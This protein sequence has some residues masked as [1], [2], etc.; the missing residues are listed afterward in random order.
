M[1][2]IHWDSFKVYA[3]D[4]FKPW[5]LILTRQFLTQTQNGSSIEDTQHSRRKPCMGQKFML[6]REMT[7]RAFFNHQPWNREKWPFLAKV[8]QMSRW[9]HWR[10]FFQSQTYLKKD[11][12]VFLKGKKNE[13]VCLE[14]ELSDG[15]PALFDCVETRRRVDHVINKALF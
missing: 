12:T 7:E 9:V 5:V 13:F 14:F 6:I 3:P 1:C 4:T 11:K 10:F 8:W 15:Y 2:L